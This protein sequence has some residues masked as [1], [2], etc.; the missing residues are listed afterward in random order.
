MSLVVGLDRL[1]QVRREVQQAFGDQLMAVSSGF[2]SMDLY[3]QAFTRL[4][5]W[6]N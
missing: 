6:L 4:G 2:G 1:D 3:K 5:D